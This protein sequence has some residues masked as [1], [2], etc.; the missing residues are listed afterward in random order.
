MD[1]LI[2]YYRMKSQKQP[3]IEMY[4][5]AI[6]HTVDFKDECVKELHVLQKMD[7]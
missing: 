2:L 7:L 1:H 3:I 6:E 5:K 4:Q